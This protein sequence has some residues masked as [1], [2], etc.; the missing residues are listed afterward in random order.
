MGRTVVEPLI[1]RVCFWPVDDGAE[2]ACGATGFAAG[3]A[4]C[5]VTKAAGVETG[6]GTA[7]DYHRCY[8]QDRKVNGHE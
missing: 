4:F 1:L 5:A 3:T 6:V 8:K 2:V 7:R